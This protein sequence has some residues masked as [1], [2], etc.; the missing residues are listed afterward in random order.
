VDADYLK[1]VY[2][3]LH[4]LLGII[5]SAASVLLATA[6]GHPPGLVFVPIVLVIW[7]TGHGLLWL[8]RKLAVKG[9]LAA[10]NHS[11]GDSKW[12]ILLILLVCLFGT[13]FIFGAFGLA[14]QVFSGSR[15]GIGQNSMIAIWLTT[16][17]CFFGILLRQDWSRI[18]AGSGF[19]VLA[20]I[21][22]YEMIASFMRGYRN[23]SA[24]W[25]TVVILFILLVLLGQHILRSSRIKDF[26]V[27]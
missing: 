12:P 19:I 6:K 26:F 1:P 16:S 22:L 18:L 7:F 20:A 11:V 3:W 10:S 8:S 17:L 24:E 23:S 25:A 14:W 21:M 15:S 27:R 13:V 5:G 4:I 2:R 9:Q